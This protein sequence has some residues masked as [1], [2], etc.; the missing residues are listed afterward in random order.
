MKQFQLAIAVILALMPGV[1]ALASGKSALETLNRTFPS[2]SNGGKGW[3]LR[4][5]S[6]PGL[7]EATRDLDVLYISKD[8]RYI[9]Q[10]EVFHVSS[11]TNLTEATQN[12][13]R[14]ELLASINRAT[15]VSFEAEDPEYEIIVFTDPTCGFCRAMHGRMEEYN[16]AGIT[17][18]YAAF[19]RSG[20]NS[21]AARLMSSIWCGNDPNE[22]MDR[23]KRQEDIDPA[24]CEESPVSNHYQLGQAFGATG[25]PAIFLPNGRMIPGYIEPDRLSAIL[26]QSQ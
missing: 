1:F 7:L 21:H 14:S 15:F 22:L 19:P 4:E 9:I 18:H 6:I 13:S 16:R 23:A 20:V 25:T 10:G 8:G 5:T 2:P 24:Q 17:I 26:T 3:T 11:G 12:E